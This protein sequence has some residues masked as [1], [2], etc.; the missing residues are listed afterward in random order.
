MDT[1]KHS[2]KELSNFRCGANGVYPGTC[3]RCHQEDYTN[4][5][6]DCINCFK[7]IGDLRKV[8]VE[9]VFMLDRGCLS[10]PDTRRHPT[11]RALKN[12]IKVLPWLVELADR[13]FCPKAKEEILIREAKK[14]MDEENKKDLT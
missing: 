4:V 10:D 9:R 7:Y 13:K 5:D 1:S 8:D 11:I 14:I 6:G 2:K 3:E 12:F